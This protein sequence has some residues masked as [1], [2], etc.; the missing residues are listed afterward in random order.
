MAASKIFVLVRV[1]KRRESISVLEYYNNV[2]TCMM[3]Y[4]LIVWLNPKRILCFDWL[5][6]RARKA[7][8]SRSGFPALVPQEKNFSFWSYSILF[9][10]QACLVKIAGYWPVFFFFSFFVFTNLDFV[11]LHK[12][13][14]VNLANIQSS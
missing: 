3:F 11:S 6:E 10:D 12:S 14:K 13:A 4:L 2:E 7:Y 1:M 8:P 5:P 9:F